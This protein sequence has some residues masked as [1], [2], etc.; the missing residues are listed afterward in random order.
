MDHENGSI[1]GLKQIGNGVVWV[2]ETNKLKVLTPAQ[3]I[4]GND[5]LTRI[6]I[7]DD[8]INN[9]LKKL[10]A[11]FPGSPYVKE[12]KKSFHYHYCNFGYLYCEHFC[13]QAKNHQLEGMCWCEL[14]HKVQ[15][16]GYQTKCVKDNSDET[17][18]FQTI[19]LNAALESSLDSLRIAGIKD[20]SKKESDAWFVVNLLMII[21]SLAF[22]VGF[23][24]WFW[25]KRGQTPLIVVP[26]VRHLD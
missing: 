20:A 18:A 14:G 24:F 9:N 7:N 26:Y 2:D 15:H 13:I 21:L 16:G 12:F 25:K 6:P 17:D 22:L 19:Q 11:V 3:N 10:I 4:V 8:R 1:Q 23:G 5:L